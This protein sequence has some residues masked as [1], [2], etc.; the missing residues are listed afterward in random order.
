MGYEMT[1]WG[2]DPSH[3]KF[4]YPHATG[5]VDCS[6][7]MAACSSSNYGMV[8]KGFGWMM[9]YKDTA[10]LTVTSDNGKFF[11]TRGHLLRDATLV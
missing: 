7:G 3:L 1:Y 10:S 8:A 5:K 2:A 6:L 4:R 9:T 11:M